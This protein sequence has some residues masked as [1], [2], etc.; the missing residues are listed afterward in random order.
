MSEATKR[1]LSDH[2]AT[3][4]KRLRVERLKPVPAY[5]VFATITAAA[6]ISR[7]FQVM[8]AAP[9]LGELE[10]AWKQIVPGAPFNRELA[11]K[12]AVLEAKE[13]DLEAK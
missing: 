9:T 5:E 12:L 3:Q 10:E 4:F 11:Q 6:G 13:S 7:A 2:V 8:I 1:N